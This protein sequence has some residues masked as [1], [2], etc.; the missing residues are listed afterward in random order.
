M[1]V[2]LSDREAEI[3]VLALCHMGSQ[4]CDVRRWLEQDPQAVRGASN[5]QD[6]IGPL[7]EKIRLGAKTA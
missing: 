6:E 1:A 4:L 5:L 3:C 2:H 7:V